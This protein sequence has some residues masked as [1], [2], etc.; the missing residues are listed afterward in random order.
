MSQVNKY[1]NRAAYE[2]DNSRLKTQSAV[3]YVEDDGEL[4]YDGVNTVV[5]K[6]AAGVG[7]LVVFDKT[8]EVLKF[9]KGATLVADKMP[10]ELVPAGVVYGRHGDKVRIVSLKNAIVNGSNVMRWANSYKVALWGFDLAAG[11]TAVLTFGTG[12]YKVDLPL[13]WSAGAKLSDIHAQIN[14]FVTGQIKAYG[15]TSSVDE[16]NSRIIMSSNTWSDVYGVIEVVSGCQITRPPEDINYQTTLTGVLIEGSTEYVRRNNGVNSSFA[17]CNPEKFLQ[18]YSA[19]GTAATGITPGSSTII[20]ESAFTEE[21]NPELV[22]AYPT[23]RDYLFR[24]HLLQYPAAY[25]ALLR[26]GKANTHLIGGLRFV[27]IHGESVPRYPAAAAALDYGVTVEGA[28]TGLEAGAWWLPSVDE[29]YLLMHD[30]VLTSADRE[31]DPVNRTLSRLGKTTCY[32]SGYYPWTSCE[33]NSNNAFIYN[34]YA[35]YVG[36][37]GKCNALAVRTVSAL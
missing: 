8:D 4:V 25:G 23:Y 27:D 21:A 12:I 28:T 15:W 37:N 5:R 26:D 6:S 10:A 11:G 17:G 33:Y 14:S 32:G 29:V 16:A 7:D 1:A 9:I 22:A 35:G 3:S 24:E 19:N 2:A 34:G 18:Y 31:S 30:R 20:R 36:N 13:T